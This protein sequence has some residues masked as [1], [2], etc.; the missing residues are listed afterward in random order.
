METQ[1]Y[2]QALARGENI[3]LSARVQKS[4]AADREILSRFF[5]SPVLKSIVERCEEIE[6]KKI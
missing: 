2:K 3:D 4:S 6:C 5:R 1:K